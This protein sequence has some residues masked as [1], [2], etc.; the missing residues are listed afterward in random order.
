MKKR[1]TFCHQVSDDMLIRFGP[2]RVY[3]CH[4]CGSTKKREFRQVFRKKP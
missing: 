4:A 1:C 2:W 3:L